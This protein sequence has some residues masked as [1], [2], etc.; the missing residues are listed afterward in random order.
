[1]D[2]RLDY[3]HD[4]LLA[5]PAYEQRLCILGRQLHG[6]L[7]PEGTYR[8]PRT[9]WRRP[10]IDAWKKRLE[11]DGQPTTLI[12]PSV[13]PPYFPNVQQA[14]L[15]LRN[16]VVEPISL[17]LTMTAIVE[18]S[19]KTGLE[20]I[21][22]PPLDALI[23]ESI[24]ETCLGH[25]YKGLLEAHGRDEAGHGDEGGHDVMWEV[26]RDL[27]FNHPPVPGDARERVN[28][29]PR[30]PP[31]WHHPEIPREL[32]ALL[33]SL[34]ALLGME[35]FN[36]NAMTWAEEL[37]S[38]PE[39]SSR[40]DLAGKVISFIQQDEQIHVDYLS[41]AMLEL[42]TRTFIT[43]HGEVAAG[44]VVDEITRRVT[45]VHVQQRRQFIP[46]KKY[47]DI[48]DVLSRHPSGDRIL[49]EFGQLGELPSSAAGLLRA[50]P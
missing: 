3:S 20:A 9:L 29:R 33:T 46:Q 24:Q 13:V 26:A 11:A 23:K 30:R 47:Q 38:D 35:I 36:D 17:M 43:D 25:L 16:G 41:I 28:N 22:K 18:G 19:G 42:R 27:A 31:E 34:I 5:E 1:M 45:S 10:A 4:E 40:P 32:E 6:G 2:L 39:V 15:L 7:T 44:P 37:L 49:R 21:P 8:S 48:Q 50:H 12:D 14:R